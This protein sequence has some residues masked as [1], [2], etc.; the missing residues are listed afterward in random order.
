WGNFSGTLTV[1][2]GTATLD[3]WLFTNYAS[4]SPGTVRYDNLVV[5]KQDQNILTGKSI[6]N[7]K[8]KSLGL[9]PNPGND[10]TIL[11]NQNKIKIREIRMFDNT[12]RFVRNYLNL[13]FLNREE[14]LLDL[15]NFSTGIYFINII[16]M[17]GN[18][19]REQLSILK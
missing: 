18:V 8:E 5:R 3:L 2:P 15:H 13:N 11:K 19:Y 14:I 10:F 6:T 9:Y 16:D 7:S 1:P 12:G 4:Q 17:E